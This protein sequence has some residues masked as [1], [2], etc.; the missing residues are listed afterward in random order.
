MIVVSC[1]LDVF[2]RYFLVYD[3]STMGFNFFCLEIFG[4]IYLKIKNGGVREMAEWVK[5]FFLGRHEW[6]CLTPALVGWRQAD[7]PNLPIC[8]SY[9]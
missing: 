2:C 6:K 1:F 7:D 9:L 5:C 4:V 3:L 8:C